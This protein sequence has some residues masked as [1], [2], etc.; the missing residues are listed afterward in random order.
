MGFHQIT[1]LTAEPIFKALGLL[2]IP[3]T[4]PPNQT[5]AL[6]L[7]WASGC[8]TVVGWFTGADKN[9]PVQTWESSITSGSKNQN[10][11]IVVNSFELGPSSKPERWVFSPYW[12]ESQDNCLG[13]K[14]AKKPG[15][16]ATSSTLQSASPFKMNSCRKY[17]TEAPISPEPPPALSQS[18]SDAQA[19]PPRVSL[20]GAQRGLRI[21]A[22]KAQEYA[23]GL[24]PGQP[25]RLCFPSQKWRHS[26]VRQSDFPQPSQDSIFVL[27]RLEKERRGK[28]EFF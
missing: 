24:G 21:G 17:H 22:G 27:H 5:F 6:S 1:W 10:S 28:G 8:P 14:G 3:K 16:E 26:Q 2:F 18:V 11:R 12:A 13:K 4:Q 20:A 7:G 15:P 9:I 25:R 19:R 23:R